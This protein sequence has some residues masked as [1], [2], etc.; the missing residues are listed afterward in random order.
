PAH[1]AAVAVR[2]QVGMLVQ[3]GTERGTRHVHPPGQLRE[4][5][6]PFSGD[7]RLNLVGP[8]GS[9]AGHTQNGSAVRLTSRPCTPI[10]RAALPGDRSRLARP[11]PVGEVTTGS[12]RFRPGRG[13][14]GTPRRGPCSSRSTAARTPATPSSPPPGRCSSARGSPPSPGGAPRRSSRPRR[15]TRPPPGRRRPPPPPAPRPA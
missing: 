1:P 13:R 3:K 6:G 10:G 5:Y 4:R 14:A 2:T 12:G 9:V 11:T 7:E 15:R 8:R